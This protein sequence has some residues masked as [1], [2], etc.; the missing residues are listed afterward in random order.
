MINQIVTQRFGKAFSEIDNLLS[1][2]RIAD[3]INDWGRTTWKT[4]QFGRII[5]DWNKLTN[6]SLEEFMFDAA[7]IGLDLRL[8]N[9][10][11]LG[12][13]VKSEEI[14]KAA[15]RKATLEVDGKT[16]EIREAKVYEIPAIEE[17]HER[18]VDAK[19][20]STF[21]FDLAKEVRNIAFMAERIRAH[22]AQDEKTKFYSEKGF[23]NGGQYGA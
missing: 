15:V 1:K 13:A 14:E 4:D 23:N 21:V 6:D 8:E 2:I 7:V 11:I 17:L 22:R 16:R 20:L 5:Q 10:D 9:E 12:D 18:T 19:E 3:G